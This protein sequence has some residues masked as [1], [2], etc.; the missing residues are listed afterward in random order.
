M[1]ASGDPRTLQ[2]FFSDCMAHNLAG[3][4]EGAELRIRR[5]INEMLGGRLLQLALISD[6]SNGRDAS[7][8]VAG[9]LQRT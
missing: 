6:A 5:M 9:T 7:A 3:T 1:L 2:E 8:L 4:G